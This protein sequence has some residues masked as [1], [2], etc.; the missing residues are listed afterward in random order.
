[1][2]D[3]SHPLSFFDRSFIMNEQKTRPDNTNMNFARSTR[4]QLIYLFIFVMFLIISVIVS[5]KSSAG[6]K[7]EM[8]W[9]G[10]T[11]VTEEGVAV[12]PEEI[13]LGSHTISKNIKDLP[14]D[15][16][17]LCF[18]SID[19][20][21]TV[22][23]DDKQIYDYHP[24]IPGRFGKSYGMFVHTIPIPDDA[25]RLSIHV[26]PVFPSA[27]A[28]IDHLMIGDAGQYML[29]FFRNNLFSF[30]QSAVT[31]LLGFFFLIVGLSSAIMMRSAGIDFISFGI[32]CM[33]IGFVGFNDTLLL[34]LLT[35]R[36]ELIRVLTYVC[37]MFLPFPALSF[38]AGSTGFG[39]SKL[40]SGMM[41]ICLVNFAAQVLLTH[42]GVTDYFYLVYVS[43][44]IIALNIAIAVWF[45]IQARRR[46]LIRSELI[47]SVS[48]SLAGCALGVIIDLL[49]FHLLQSHGSSDF[50]R[51]GVFVFTAVIGIFL[52][53][54]QTTALKQKQMESMTL[55]SEITEAF[56]KV[57]DMKDRYTN[58]HSARVAKY[59]AMLS[60]ELGYDDET[61]E[62]Y[63]RIALLHDV[64]KI[65]IPKALL[66]KPGKLTEGEYAV[67]KSHTSQGY[68]ALKDI[69]IMP[70]LAVGAQSH[71]E[72]PD[73]K[74]YP[75]GLSDGEI[76][77]VAQII[78]VADCFDAMYSDRPYRKRMNFDKAVSIIREVSG[79]QL[80]PDV[81]DA[82]LRLVDKGEFRIPG[83]TGE[84]STED[85]N[86]I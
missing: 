51:L 30:G 12:N 61:V 36:P 43:H 39:H 31:L 22:Y 63:Y 25:S 84:G 58:G 86:N 45:V 11:W 27:A 49:R 47:K 18:R 10:D 73:G 19:T 41:I 34:Q 24:E 23:A 53:R 80:T 46:G 5:K 17:S 2:E 42:K 48:W 78:A 20:D 26:D 44:V 13:P 38:F 71:H 85:I 62:K 72:R 8:I 68:D 21:F 28:G 40:V 6:A 57:I 14:T 83:D 16:E 81:V 79:T 69:S 64:G 67:I 3:V 9:A 60:K 76:P 82:F 1:M 70:E 52:F 65:G 74:G 35:G 4:E 37:L 75:N 15:G 33:L 55:V 66:N 50:T 7:H 77:R 59:T 29:Y 32:T 54:D 56:A